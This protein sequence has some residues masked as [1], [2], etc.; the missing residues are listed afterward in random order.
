[1]NPS[2]LYLAVDL[3]G[4]SGRVLAGEFDRGRIHLHELN[5]FEN[6]ALELPSGRHWNITGIYQDILDGLKAAAEKY[7]DRPASLGIDTWGVDYA[8][9]DQNG[10]V[11]GIPFQYRDRRTE[12]MME[13]AFDK[14]PPREL[15]QSTGIQMMPFNTVFQLL[16]GLESQPAVLHA[17]ED[18]LFTPDLLGF[19]LTGVKTQERSIVSTSQLYN[20]LTADWDRMLI[21]RLGFPQRLFK[22]I[23]D[24]ATPLGPLRKTLR[25]RTGLHR[26]QVISVGGHDT[27]SAVAAVPSPHKSP[28]FLSSG[29]WSLMGL[30][31]PAPVISDRSF[32][33]AFTNETGVG[34]STRFLKNICGLWL[35]QECRRH[36]REQG[37]DLSYADMSGLAAG[38]KAFRSLVDPDAPRFAE[39]GHMPRKIQTFCRETGQ[40]VPESPGEIIRCIYESLALRYAEVWKNLPHYTESTPDQLHIV[41]GGCQDK[42]LNQFT[43]NAINAPVVA[44]PVEATGLGNIL[45]QMLADGTINSL[46]EGRALVAAS[47]PLEEYT[48]R[49]TQAWE[50]MKERFALLRSP[51]DPSG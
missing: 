19:W 27:A 26:L 47:F 49:D 16:S 44:G 31:L 34:G 17:A 45:A 48:P 4:G 37:Q 40:P 41:G 29:T 39:A 18:L 23:R 46:A 7:G 20:P 33:D 12:G 28:A 15:Y 35:I 9:L 5:R 25:E 14:I 36:W 10:H 30:E 43:S 22:P 2:T 24:P 3:G 8:L 6:R 38:A 1:M 32:R 21:E 42:L 11:L 13:K 50:A 51:P